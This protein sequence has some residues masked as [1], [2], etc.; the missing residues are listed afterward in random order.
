MISAHK[1]KGSVALGKLINALRKYD[2]HRCV[3]IRTEDDF[4]EIISPTVQ[5]IQRLVRK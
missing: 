1:S 3:K 4:S 5:I 2:K